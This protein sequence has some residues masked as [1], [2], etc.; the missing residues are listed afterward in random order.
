M[1]LLGTHREPSNLTL[2]PAGADD[3]LRVRTRGAVQVFAAPLIDDAGLFR[4]HIKALVL[5]KITSHSPAA[6]MHIGTW[7]KHMVDIFADPTVADPGQIDMQLR[8]H[9]WG[10]IAQQG[11]HSNDLDGEN[12]LVGQETQFGWLIF[13]E[14]AK[15]GKTMFDHMRINESEP[16]P[17]DGLNRFRGPR[18][19]GRSI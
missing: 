3:S 18:T 13:G 15:S 2:I 12:D 9:V 11:F 4:V 16:V 14:I 10:L 5:K 8:A 17:V 7:P 19:G 6:P 1:Q